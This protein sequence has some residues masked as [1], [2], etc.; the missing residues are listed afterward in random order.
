MENGI[1]CINLNLCNLGASE[2]YCFCAQCACPRSWRRSDRSQR[3]CKL[4][5]NTLQWVSQQNCKYSPCLIR[6]AA[7]Q[8]LNQS[9][10]CTCYPKGFNRL[11]YTL[12]TSGSKNDCLQEE[13]AEA[14]EP[15]SSWK[16]MPQLSQSGNE[17]LESPWRVAGMEFTKEGQ[18]S[19]SLMA[20]AGGSGSS[21]RHT[22]A[23]K[24]WR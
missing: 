11:A 21:N 2:C 13:E 20:G 10:V 8:T 16:R 23:G 3:K 15:L 22:K 7:L 1:C 18:N 9:A 14:T 5:M 6:K 4:S 17:S 19:W 12:G 24:N